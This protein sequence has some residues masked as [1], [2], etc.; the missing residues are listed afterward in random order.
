MNDELAI[1]MVTALKGI[2][3]ELK[4]LNSYFGKIRPPSYQQTDQVNELTGLVTN[5]LK[6][7]VPGGTV[8]GK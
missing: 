2:H 3:E 6:G 8:N 7:F 4:I 1:E 5:L